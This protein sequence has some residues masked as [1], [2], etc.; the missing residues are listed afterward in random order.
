MGSILLAGALA[1]SL[2]LIGILLGIRAFRSSIHHWLHFLPSAAGGVFSIITFSLLHEAS[3]LLSPLALGGAAISGFLIAGAIG[4][5][6]PEKSECHGP[7]CAPRLPTRAQRVLLADS[8]HNATDGIA[9]A[10]AFTAS[11]PLGWGVAIGV[12]FHEVVQELSEFF[13][14]LEAG[15]PLRRALRYNLLSSLTIFVGIALGLTAIELNAL[16]GSLLAAVSAGTFAYVVV[17]DILPH[18]FHYRQR[19]DLL[20]H[21]A[22]AAVGMGGMLLISTLFAHE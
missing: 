7:F 10:S 14:Y 1:A 9:L 3:H 20:T 4:L 15:L 13:V 5:I 6:A 21:L 8:L 12:I 16:F 18:T 2:S 19:R 17:R 22:V 11:H